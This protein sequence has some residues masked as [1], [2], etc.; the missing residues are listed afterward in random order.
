MRNSNIE[1]LRILAM[2]LILMLHVDFYSLG[3]PSIRDTVEF[4]LS[5]FARCSFQTLSL[6]SVNLFVLISGWFS[7]NFNI[8]RL[9]AF[10]FQS[11]F[12]I[13]L[14]YAIGLATGRA[15]VDEQQ[16]LE[17]IFL[18]RFGWFIKAYV[19]LFILSPVLN[20]YARTASRRQFTLLLICFYSFQTVWACLFQSAKFIDGGCS[21]FSF[22]G[23]YLLA[24]YV[25]KYG[26]CIVRNAGKI[27]I[28]STLIYVAWGYLPLCFGV[29]RLFY[30]SLVYTN[31]LNI[32]AALSLLL[33]A[34][35]IKPRYNTFINYVA[36]S[37]FAVYLGHMC[38]SWSSGLYAECAR[39]IY[40]DWS[41][42]EYL[43]V[44]T[45]FMLSVFTLSIIID[46]PRRL[47]WGYISGI[48]N[49]RFS[50]SDHITPPPM[51]T[52][53]NLILAPVSI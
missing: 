24:Q 1:A 22:V 42:G 12:I 27:F 51:L 16:I 20:S 44:I 13:S 34:V 14:V 46:I 49:S 15:A 21:T 19:G 32:I 25:R 31:P 29:G 43:F 45:L 5:T 41:G 50:Q 2:F 39:K 53:I 18:G 38:N 28:F 8:R 26:E 3:E 10:V 33:L 4:P 35:R 7:I 52:N 11:V 47:I 36:A 30:M 9:L 17:C 37:T 6:I 48:Y 40:T 23:L